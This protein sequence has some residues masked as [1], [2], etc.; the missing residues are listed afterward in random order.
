MSLLASAIDQLNERQRDAMDVEGHCVILAPPGSGKTKL[1]VTRLSRDLADRIEPPRGA[2]CITLTN[3]A[4]L[5][6][7]SRFSELSDDRRSNLFIGT[8]HGF[9]LNRIVRPY[10]KVAGVVDTREMRVLRR[11]EARSAWVT[12]LRESGIADDDLLH[13]T[14]TKLRS[15][16]AD[17]ER[18]ALTGSAMRARNAYLEFLRQHGLLDFQSIISHAVTI[19]ADPDVRTALRSSFE[20]IYVDE[21]Q[22]LAPGLDR[23][24]RHLCISSENEPSTLFAVGDTDQ[25]IYGWTGTD[26]RLL[27]DLARQPGVKKIEL[28]TNYRCGAVIA[29]ISRRLY[30]DARTVK[31]VS[32]GGS[33]EAVQVPGGIDGQVEHI[34]DEVTTLLGANVEPTSI[35]ILCRTNVIARSAAR[36]LQDRHIDTWVREDADWETMMSNWLERSCGAVLGLLDT[37]VGVGTLLDELSRILPEIDADVR[38]EVLAILLAI[39]PGMSAKE[40]AQSVLAAVED[41]SPSSTEIARDELSPLIAHLADDPQALS[42]V[43]DLASRQLRAGRVY[44]TTLSAGK[45]LEFDHV[46]I[47]D[48]DDGR[49]PFYQSFNNPRELA[50]ER[51]KFYVGLTRARVSVTLLWS[52]YTV[53]RN[54]KRWPSRVSRFVRQLRLD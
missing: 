50:E 5:E 13:T 27:T 36:A 34:A 11:K 14:V 44:V 33:V 10:G 30:S 20:R 18:W 1:L 49:I 52:G 28:N 4:G 35:G 8:V 38:G 41:G 42:T 39:E 25:A 19:V 21:Y 32:Q 45:G 22:D 46:F 23:I 6:I 7:V 48:C 24:V 17:D 43:D 53:D 2:A 26:A 16:L 51:N 31:A 40:L 15:E 37:N 12:A 9:A 47:P 54:G 29:E 3:A